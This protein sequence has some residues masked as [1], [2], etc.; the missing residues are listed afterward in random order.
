MR[1]NLDPA[2]LPRGQSLATKI[3]GEEARRAASLRPPH[4]RWHVSRL[5]IAF[6]ELVARN[7]TCKLRAGPALCVLS[8]CCKTFSPPR[9]SSAAGAGPS[10]VVGTRGMPSGEIWGGNGPAAAA[11][12]GLTQ[13]T[14]SVFPNSHTCHDSR[15]NRHPAL[16]R[17]RKVPP[18]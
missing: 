7:R 11:L 18:T 2:G 6:R 4:I 8:W 1:T 13:T 16:P 9:G 10:W 12:I 3:T 14:R 17:W 5:A 15:N